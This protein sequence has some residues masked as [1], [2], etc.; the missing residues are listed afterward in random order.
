MSL[1]LFLV[2][3]DHPAAL[4]LADG[5]N[6]DLLGRLR[7]DAA[8]VFCFDFVLVNVAELDFLLVQPRLVQRDLGERVLDGFD[9]GKLH[10]H[11][12]VALF[13][14]ELDAHVLVAVVFL[15]EGGQQ[16]VLDLFHHLLLGDALFL[17]EQLER[18]KKFL[19]HLFLS[20]SKIYS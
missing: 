10:E 19:I 5:L 14:V 6:D 9:H 20:A 18:L 15:A 16:R 3:A 2:L 1:L 12:H 8:E 13:G 17:F 7:R 4:G 11:P